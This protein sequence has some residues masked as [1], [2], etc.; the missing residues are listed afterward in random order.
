MSAK[1]KGESKGDLIEWF[2]VSYGSIAKVALVL[3]VLGVAVGIYFYS[4][5]LAGKE[6][7]VAPPAAL[8]RF[9]WIE[10]AVQIKGTGGSEWRAASEADGLFAHDFIRTA[11]DATAEL[12]FF[13]GTVVRIG[14]DS[15]VSLE[16][17]SEHATTHQRRVSWHIVG[18]EAQ[19]QTAAKRQPQDE[20]TVVMAKGRASLSGDARA[21]VSVSSQG[22]ST[23]RLFSGTGEVETAK[24]ERFSLAPAN[25]LRIDEQGQTEGVVR[26]LPPPTIVGPPPEETIPVGAKGAAVRLRWDPVP[27]AVS[28]R[29]VLDKSGTFNWPIVDR[30]GVQ[31]TSI[32][33]KGLEVGRYFWRLAATGEN[34]LTGDFSVPSRLIVVP[35]DA[36]PPMLVIE[37]TSVRGAVVNI[38]GR[39]EP[40]S[41][42]TI[43]RQRAKL[44]EK[45]AFNE[46]LM[47]TNPGT[48]QLRVRVIGPGG[49]VAESSITVTVTY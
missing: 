28:Y 9:S 33:L 14:P 16:D 44:D 5:Y 36:A 38:L 35:K 20:T 3:A 43:D 2:T 48:Q 8:V 11:S 21:H 1:R 24:A 6:L 49:G 39:T 27:G 15:L 26:L 22:T 41:I 37:S 34:A 25:A 12:S 18:G 31:G 19:I 45:G 7:P 29:V 4:K 32:D 40:G 46:F 10:G 23:I 42:V 13:D 47:V 30:D 17:I